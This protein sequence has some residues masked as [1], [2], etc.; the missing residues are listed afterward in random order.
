MK[1][2]KAK[3]IIGR[4]RVRG[5]F[6]S[7]TRYRHTLGVSEAME[8]VECIGRYRSPKFRI[9]DSNIFAYENIIKWLLGDPTM[10]AIDP[11]SKQIVEG[12][13]EA[14]IYVAGTTG[15]GKSWLLE[16]INALAMEIIPS[17]SFD[18]ESQRA[19]TWLNVRADDIC[20]VWTREGTISKYK[21][22]PLIGIQDLGS[23]PE[24]ALYMGNRIE[25]LRSVLEARGDRPDRI[26]LIT[27][28]YPMGH[29]AL[30]DRYGERVAS[31]LAE[32]CNYFEI[33]GEDRRKR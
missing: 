14:G 33:R 18:R 23:E 11:R 19:L 26:T 1:T 17:V 6:P 25:P 2:E 7:V 10:R 13:L 29:S 8:I 28:N 27:S 5:S 31:R 32:M 21:S 30:V 15:V 16:V 4:L 22:W 20:E 9:D 12:R 24:E 3:E